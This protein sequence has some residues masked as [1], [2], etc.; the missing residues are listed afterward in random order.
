M[1]EKRQHYEAFLQSLQSW[2]ESLLD[3]PVR[4]HMRAMWEVCTT[5]YYVQYA[6]FRISSL[7]I[8]CKS[9]SVVFTEPQVGGLIG[10]V[11]VD[12]FCQVIY[13]LN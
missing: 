9:Q 11:K 5:A 6:C 12:A 2:E 3:E 4:S 1:M 13:T 10:Q 7:L 8:V